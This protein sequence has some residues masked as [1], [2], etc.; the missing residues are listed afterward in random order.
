MKTNERVNNLQAELTYEKLKE[1][2][3]FENVT[4]AESVKIIE[5]IKQLA[6]NL[7]FL[8]QNEQQNLKIE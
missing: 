1:Y 3:G 2:K 6:K 7:F 8:Y 4:E 5:G